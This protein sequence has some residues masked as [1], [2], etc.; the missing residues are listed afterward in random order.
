MTFFYYFLGKDVKILKEEPF[1]K[2]HSII[3]INNLD[4]FVPDDELDKSFLED[5]GHGDIVVKTSKETDI[6]SDER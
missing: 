1:I 4:D 3:N 5:S 2:T 6:H